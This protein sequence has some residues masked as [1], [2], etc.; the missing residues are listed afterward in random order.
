MSNVWLN[1]ASRV[2]SILVLFW[3]QHVIIYLFFFFLL[4]CV[5]VPSI[6]TH[7]VW[8]HLKYQSVPTE[9]NSLKVLVLSSCRVQSVFILGLLMLPQKIS[10]KPWIRCVLHPSTFGDYSCS[11]SSP[12]F[13]N[14]NL[15]FFFFY[16]SSSPFLRGVDS[17]A[18]RMLIIFF[19]PWLIVRCSSYYYFLRLPHLFQSFRYEST[20]CQDERCF[21]ALSLPFCEYFCPR[22]LTACSRGV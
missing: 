11:L 7:I 19:P 20:L 22:V 17:G 15:H 16:A 4:L 5:F 13:R 10:L 3:D 6:S 14:M 1:F 2:V 9:I 12:I 18:G 21:E 8:H